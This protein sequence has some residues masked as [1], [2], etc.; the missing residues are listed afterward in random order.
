MVKRK[1][2]IDDSL[3]EKLDNYIRGACNQ[4]QNINVCRHRIE[5][6][7]KLCMK[8]CT[9]PEAKEIAQ[10]IFNKGGDS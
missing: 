2:L 10:G 1:I 3:A 7:N 9:A 4:A 5:R 8:K 6:K